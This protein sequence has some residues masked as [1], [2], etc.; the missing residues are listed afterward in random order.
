MAEPPNSNMFF[1]KLH[2]R[3]RH[4]MMPTVTHVEAQTAG[5]WHPQP[6]QR[7]YCCYC[8]SLE[9]QY[10]KIA[11][12]QGPT[13]SRSRRRTNRQRAESGV[14]PGNPAMSPRSSG[15]L[16][17]VS[18]CFACH[19]E[20]FCP[21]GNLPSNGHIGPRRARKKQQQRLPRPVTAR[22]RLFSTLAR[23]VKSWFDLM[24]SPVGGGGGFPLIYIL[25]IS[26][27][28]GC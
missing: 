23:V 19:L 6:D 20:C 16:H 22:L 5:T 11:G 14:S 4:L 26:S 2:P 8:N 10:P 9:A 12:E 24:P 7:S 18:C 28:I 27:S 1:S 13:T 17:S 15:R 25:G 3:P 21:L